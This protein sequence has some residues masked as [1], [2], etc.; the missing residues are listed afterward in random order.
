MDRIGTLFVAL[1]VL[2]AFFWL[3]ESLFPANRNQP[4]LLRR[5]GLRT[6]VFY[7]FVTPLAT[8][9]VSQIGLAVILVVIY[10]ENVAG[11]RAMLA[12][13]DTF[14]AAQPLALQAILMIAIGDFIG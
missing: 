8:R 14:L 9:A 1:L 7:W 6:D 2:S 12:S 13:R 5:R 11:I 4:G 3:V 10:R